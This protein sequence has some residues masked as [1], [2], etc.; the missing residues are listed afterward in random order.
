MSVGEEIRKARKKAGLTQLDLAERAGLAHI[1]VHQYEAGK[2]QPGIKQIKSIAKALD[3][4]V[5]TLI[6]SPEEAAAALD[7]T[8]AQGTGVISMDSF[9][10]AL[11]NETRELSKSDKELILSMARQLNEARKKGERP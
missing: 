2:R 11:Q 10:Y 1:T 3:I 8:I 6:D 9:T 7:E 4:P 5:S